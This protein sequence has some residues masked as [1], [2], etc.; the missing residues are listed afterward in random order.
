MYITYYSLNNVVTSK[1]RVLILN[2]IKPD[3]DE[4]DIRLPLLS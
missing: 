2:D 1:Y 4:D 3:I